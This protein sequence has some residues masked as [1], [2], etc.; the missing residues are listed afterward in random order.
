M[1]YCSHCVNHAGL[2]WTLYC[3]AINPDHQEKCRSEAKEVLSDNDNVSWFV[4]YEHA[5]VIFI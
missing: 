5:V 2:S 4:L 1:Y 3:L